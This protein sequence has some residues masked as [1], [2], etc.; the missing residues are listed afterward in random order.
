MGIIV[1]TSKSSY[2]GLTSNACKAL[3]TVSDFP[4]LDV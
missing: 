1:T 2:E 3:G 4:K